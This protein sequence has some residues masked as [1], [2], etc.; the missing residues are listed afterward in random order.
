MAKTPPPTW[1]HPTLG[2]FRYDGLNWVQE[3]TLPAIKAFTYGRYKRPTKT[4]ASQIELAFEVDRDGE[5]P[6]PAAATLA[7]KVLANQNLFPTQLTEALWLDL[8][9]DGPPSGMWWHGDLEQVADT[10]EEGTPPTQATDMFK[11]IRPYQ[12]RILKSVERHKSPIVEIKFRA[13]FEE[14][15]GLGILTDG[16]TILGLG[17]SADA[18]PFKTP[19]KPPAK[20]TKPPTRKSPPS[21]R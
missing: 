5:L 11:L 18:S 16:I 12:I 14:E 10:I 4:K 15:H 21:K 17:Y 2:A 9:G 6:S 13:A 8:T 20:K 7:V 19:K 1:T 3:I